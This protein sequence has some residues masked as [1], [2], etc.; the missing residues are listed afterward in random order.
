M[1]LY[2]QSDWQEIWEGKNTELVKGYTKAEN[3]I[4]ERGI[5]YAL[6][7][8]FRARACSLMEERFLLGY[9]MKIAETIL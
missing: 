9:E 6:K 2:N 3:N 5:E 7:I 4:E 1:K 8:L